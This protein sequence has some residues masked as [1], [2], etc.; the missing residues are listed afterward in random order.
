MCLLV[1][2]SLYYYLEML[3]SS[4][5]KFGIYLKGTRCLYCVVHFVDKESCMPCRNWG[6]G[7]G[8]RMRAIETR[9]SGS[10][11]GINICQY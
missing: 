7:P 4:T 10:A 8:G 6:G 2:A 3:Y 9:V 11:E 5:N 1:P